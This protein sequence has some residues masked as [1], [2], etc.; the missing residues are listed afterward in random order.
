[1]ISGPKIQ[2]ITN[3]PYTFHSI[4][5]N[6]QIQ[7]SHVHARYSV[8]NNRFWV[9]IREEILHH[10]IP[11]ET[12]TFV[13]SHTTFTCSHPQTGKMIFIIIDQ[14]R[15]NIHPVQFSLIFRQH[16]KILDL[17]LPINHR[18]PNHLPIFFQNEHIAFFQITVD[19]RLTRVC[20]Q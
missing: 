7:I 4:L 16:R 15:N 18:F 6:L 3:K 2:K 14:R 13:I 20:I 10:M 5:T 9:I 8:I 12:I 19:H 11:H 1:M 17:P